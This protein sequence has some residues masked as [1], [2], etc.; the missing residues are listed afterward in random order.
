MTER[1]NRLI[2]QAENG[3]SSGAWRKGRILSKVWLINISFQLM[4]RDK[5]FSYSFVR[6]KIGTWRVHVINVFLCNKLFYGKKYKG[7]P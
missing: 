5:Q 4:N 6:R 2:F 7:F 1:L 3:S